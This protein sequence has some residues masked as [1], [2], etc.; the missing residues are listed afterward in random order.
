MCLE[1]LDGAER[2]SCCAVTWC[3]LV[4]CLWAWGAPKHLLNAA[5]CV[6]LRNLLFFSDPNP[7]ILNTI[8]ITCAILQSKGKRSNKT[9]RQEVREESFLEPGDV[10][11]LL[12]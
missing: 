4:R 6:V 11:L 7:T 2:S 3:V 12:F 8:V 10:L 5:Q 1:V 9:E